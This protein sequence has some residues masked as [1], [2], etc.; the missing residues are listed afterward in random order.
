MTTFMPVDLPVSRGAVNLAWLLAELP[1]ASAGDLAG[2]MGA[3]RPGLYRVLWEL[4]EAGLADAVHLGWNSNRVARWYLTDDALGA[5]GRVGLTWHDEG[6]RCLLLDRFPS[7]EWF[8]R[9]VGEIGGLGRLQQFLW[10]DGLSIDAACRFDGGWVGLWWCGM[11][12]TEK[13]IGDRLSSLVHDLRKLPSTAGDPWPGMMCFVVNDRWQKELV[14]R[15]CRKMGFEGSLALWCVSDGSRWGVTEAGASRNWIYQPVGEVLEG[16]WSWAD[17]VAALPWSQRRGVA[18][19]RVLDAVAQWP[20]GDIDLVRM[21]IGENRKF[22]TANWGLRILRNMGLVERIYDSGG[23]RY[24]LSAKGIDR[25]RR[26]DRVQFSEYGG[27][28]LADSFAKAPER[29]L[30]EV[31]VL[32]LMARFM[33]AKNSV[34]SGWR[35]SEHGASGGGVDP[36]AVV[37]LDRSPFG[38]GWHYV[39]YERSARGRHKV[40]RKLV[41]YYSKRRRDNWPVLFVCWNQEAEGVFQDVAEEH[42]VRLLTSTIERVKEHGPVGNVHCWSY[43]GRPVA[44]A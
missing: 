3:G 36:D 25:L 7:L 11:L 43:L 35:C 26:R 19:A 41:S 27:R 18:L 17:R 34:A 12:Q 33:E 42:G 30:H 4:N 38:P 24:F 28:A 20:G 29:S 39:E 37:Y 2:I 15:V 23:Y 22:R 44:V 9:V 32:D 16:G 14:V 10:L 40:E 1:L 13:V 21:M 6:L 8:Y 5:M 31:G